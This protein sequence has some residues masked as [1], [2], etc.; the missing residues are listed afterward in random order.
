[1]NRRCV[2]RRGEFVVAG[3]AWLFLNSRQFVKTRVLWRRVVVLAAAMTIVGGCK[4]RRSA[5]ESIDGQALAAAHCTH[6]HT[7]PSPAH[8]PSEE[9]PYMLAWMGNY[10]GYSPSIEIEP[11]LVNPGLVPSKPL[12]TREEFDAVGDYFLKQ[13]SVDYQYPALEPAPPVAEFLEPLP[14]PGLPSTVCLVA[15]DSQDQTLIV[16]ASNPSQAFVLERGTTRSFQVP[17][18]P[19]SY[20][21]LGEFRRLG[22]AGNLGRDIGQ[23]R[24][25]DFDPETDRTRLLVDGHERLSGHRTADIDGDGNNDLLVCGFGE[26]QTGCVCIRWNIEG[27]RREE[28]LLEEAGATWGDVADLD[29]DGDLDIVVLIGSNR[30]RIV[31]F[32]NEGNRQLAELTVQLRPVGWGYNR[33]VVVDWDGDGRLDLVE[34]TGNN[35]ELRG[36]PIKGHHGVR[37]LRNDG[38]WQFTEILFE[39]LAGAMDVAVGDFDGNGRVDIATAAFFPDWRL[40]R[41]TTFLLLLQQADGTVQRAGIPERYWNRWMRVSAGDADGDGDD[42]L[43]LGAAQVPVGVPVEHFARYQQLLVGKSSVLLLRNRTIP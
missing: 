43:L 9:W 38:D 17:T 26:A 31:A 29:G 6:C 7:E 15:V 3:G 24:V 4:D 37:V 21:R 39:H 22:L 13:S 1:M 30:P 33:G 42:D 2:G 16:G 35:L 25:F 8:L 23:G 34:I 20:E 41:P 40:D 5:T 12:M 36:R 28:V 10:I 18:E 32:V 14:F 11:T 27:E 19:I